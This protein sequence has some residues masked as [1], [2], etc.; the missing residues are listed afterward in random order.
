LFGHAAG[1]SL[2]FEEFDQAQ[3]LLAGEIAIVEKSHAEVV[4]GVAA[5]GA[6]AVSP[7]QGVEAAGAALGTKTLMVFPAKSQ[8][9]LFCG[10]FRFDNFFVVFKLH[11]IKFLGK[12][13]AY[14]V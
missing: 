5:A 11:M 4:E 7:P 14:Y 9:E 1:G 12:N 8:Q 3:P 2:Q 13:L 6:A 10:I